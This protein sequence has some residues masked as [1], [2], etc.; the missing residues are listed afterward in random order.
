MHVICGGG[1]MHVPE[2]GHYRVPPVYVLY[3]Y[4]YICIYVCTYI[5]T[6][7]YTHTHIHTHTH[8]HT[9]VR[10]CHVPPVCVYI[11]T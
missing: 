6:H 10:H 3:I 4:I 2:V 7:T 1:Y 5:H 11:H 9:E 8:T